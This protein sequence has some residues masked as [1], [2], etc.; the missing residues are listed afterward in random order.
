M[1]IAE[2][3]KRNQTIYCLK[4][5]YQTPDDTEPTREPVTY[6]KLQALYDLSTKRLMDIVNREKF[7][8]QRRWAIG[9]DN[10][11]KREGQS[12]SKGK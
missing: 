7:R 4:M 10:D 2:K 9:G 8:A 11:D 3:T 1:P 12:S 5:G 6:R